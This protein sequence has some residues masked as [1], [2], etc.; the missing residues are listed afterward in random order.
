MNERFSGLDG[1]RGIAAAVVV[2]CHALLINGQLAEATRNPDADLSA[3]ATALTYSPLHLVWAGNEAVMVFFILSG[4]VLALPF[5]GP[6]RPTWAEYF[7][8]RLTRLYLPIWGA[9]AFALALA[10]L[11]PRENDHASWWV[12]AHAGP[13]D[14]PS[15]VRLVTTLDRG[16]LVDGP[17]WSMRY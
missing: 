10:T 9:V 17:L 13:L 15:L 4:F 14:V 5:D 3:G 12:N 7:P 8:R 11:V 1:L 6:R 2:V 16:L